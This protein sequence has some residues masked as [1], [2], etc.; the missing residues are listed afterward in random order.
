MN[1]ESVPVFQ[2]LPTSISR[3]STGTT[4]EVDNN[5]GYEYFEGADEDPIPV[6]KVDL[7]GH[8]I[9]ELAIAANVSIST[10]KKAIYLRE[11]QLYQEK[12]AE[13]N[14]IKKREYIR[15]STS[16]TT[17]TTTTTTTRPSTT[18]RPRMV[19]KVCFILLSL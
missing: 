3:I 5:G 2:A 9:E 4:L 10:I 12:K 11:Q 16:T 19:S 18:M 1:R 17:T 15:S 7:M 14:A 6:P 8:T 13:L